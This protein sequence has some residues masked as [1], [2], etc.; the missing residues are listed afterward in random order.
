MHEHRSPARPTP[1]ARHAR[2]FDPTGPDPTGP[3][4]SGPD[5]TGPDPSGPDPTGAAL[6][7]AIPELLP[8]VRDL[9]EA[10]DGPV[11]AVVLL[12]ALADLVTVHLAAA[13]RHAEVLGRAG[14]ALDHLLVEFDEPV[15]PAAAFFDALAPDDR[16]RVI[17]WL[18][19]AGRSAVDR[20]DAEAGGRRA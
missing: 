8:V 9:A 1:G 3:D 14:R 10:A 17:T 2:P 11:G 12:G 4:P 15:G 20:L 19:P 7:A 18:G 6:V 13:E 5:P 16:A